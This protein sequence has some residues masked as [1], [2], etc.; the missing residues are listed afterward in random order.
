MIL[1]GVAIKAE[2]L[3]R[4]LTLTSL[5]ETLVKVKDFHESVSTFP[6]IVR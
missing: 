5:V 2:S 3:K 1:V 4:P 6:L